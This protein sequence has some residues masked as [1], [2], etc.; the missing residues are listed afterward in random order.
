[1]CVKTNLKLLDITGVCAWCDFSYRAHALNPIKH[2]WD[3][4]GRVFRRRG[5]ANV[6]RFTYTAISNGRMERN[7]TA[8]VECLGYMYV[9]LMRSRC[10]TVIEVNGGHSRYQVQLICVVMIDFWIFYTCID[11]NKRNASDRIA[12]NY[13]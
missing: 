6:R 8:H 7:Y 12:I 2:D 4:I 11:V 13:E 3:V 9:T 5:L 1:M 10:H